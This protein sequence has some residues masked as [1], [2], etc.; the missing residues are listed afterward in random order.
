MSTMTQPA[1]RRSAAGARLVPARHSLIEGRHRG[2]RAGPAE[3]GT[4]AVMRRVASAAALWMLGLG[5][6]ALT[7]GWARMALGALLVSAAMTGVVALSWRREA[8]LAHR[9]TSTPA[10]YE[11]DANHREHQLT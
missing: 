7:E 9:A 11:I 1:K 10:G 3:S 8:A 2:G 5:M 6:L 4:P